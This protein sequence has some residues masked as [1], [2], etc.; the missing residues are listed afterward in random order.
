LTKTLLDAIVAIT[1]KHP[2]VDK[3]KTHPPTAKEKKLKS[4]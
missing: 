3:K 4:V 2:H 1:Q